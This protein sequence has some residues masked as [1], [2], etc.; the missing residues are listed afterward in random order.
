MTQKLESLTVRERE[1]LGLLTHGDRTKDLA[2]QLGISPRTMQKHLQRI[3]AKLGV[4]GRTAAALFAV[5][6]ATK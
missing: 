2:R 3:Y 4:E 5:R 6:A 1:V